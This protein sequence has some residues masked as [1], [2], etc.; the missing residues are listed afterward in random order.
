MSVMIETFLWSE[1]MACFRNNKAP[2]KFPIS[3]A[4]RA[5][6]NIEIEVEAEAIAGVDRIETKTMTIIDQTT[7]RRHIIVLSIP[8]SFF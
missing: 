6:L 5:F 7:N 3:Q 2:V 4:E 1:L 8:S